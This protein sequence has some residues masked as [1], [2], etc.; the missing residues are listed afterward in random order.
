MKNRIK[1]KINNLNY[2]ADKLEEQTDL[3]EESVLV[4]AIII[5]QKSLPVNLKVG[6]LINIKNGIFVGLYKEDA[7]KEKKKDEVKNKIKMN[8]NTTFNLF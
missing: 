7:E 3:F 5:K 4:K 6:D 8:K 1:F 2:F